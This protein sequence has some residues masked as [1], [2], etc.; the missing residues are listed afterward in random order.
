MSTTGKLIFALV[1]AANLAAIAAVSAVHLHRRAAPDSQVIYLGK[2]VVTPANASWKS[3]AEGANTPVID[4]GTIVVTPTE[5]DWRFA[6]AHGVHRPHA[7]V[8]SVNDA[9]SNDDQ[10]A[11]ASLL[12]AMTALSPGQYL[13]TDAT[14]RA[15]DELV[16][17][18]PGR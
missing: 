17:Q 10:A 11:T 5:A 1:I 14:L 13:D 12:Q 9:N 18:G 7:A 2:I 6:E 8:A 4:L 3:P 16:F 15:L